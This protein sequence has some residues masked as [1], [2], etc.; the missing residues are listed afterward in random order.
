MYS[1]DNYLT[2]LH[3][4]AFASFCTVSNDCGIYIMHAVSCIVGIIMRMAG[5]FFGSKSAPLITIQSS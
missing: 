2:A 5:A 4:I 3:S 1:T